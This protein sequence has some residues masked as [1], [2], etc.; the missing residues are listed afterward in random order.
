MTYSIEKITKALLNKL[1]I[2]PNEMKLWDGSQVT[3]CHLHNNI[4]YDLKELF[5]TFL[6]NHYIKDL[7]F[8]LW[9][10]KNKLLFLWNNNNYTE[11]NSRYFIQ[12]VMENKHQSNIIVDSNN[13]FENDHVIRSQ[14][15]DGLFDWSSGCVLDKIFE[16]NRSKK[17][18]QSNTVKKD[19]PPDVS[20]KVTSQI[21]GLTAVSL[22]PEAP[23][24][25]LRLT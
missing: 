1:H 24:A 18:I 15:F 22:L 21:Q 2:F 3:I 23:P 13:I 5:Q 16:N 14:L 10:V 6:I 9:N 17:N 11:K 12:P 4:N 19:T 20:L 25:S 7:Y 8:E